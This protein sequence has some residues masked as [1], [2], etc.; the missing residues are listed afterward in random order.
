[1]FSKEQVSFFFSGDTEETRVDT[2]RSPNFLDPKI[3]F[4]I[5]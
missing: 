4:S 3:L 2:T 1:L 5:W